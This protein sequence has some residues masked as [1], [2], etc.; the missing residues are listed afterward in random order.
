GGAGFIGSNTVRTLVARG[1]RV[2]VLD[3]LFLGR[4][5]NLD[6][7]DCI[8]VDGDALDGKLLQRIAKKHAIKQVY[9]FSGYT[10]APMYNDGPAT[11]MVKNLQG[12]LNILELSR[13]HALRVAYA[14]TSSFYARSPK[15]FREDMSI[16]PGTPYEF[17]KLT[18]ENAAHTYFLENGVRS[19]GLRFFSVYGPREA[20]KTR[21]ANNISQFFWSI[22]N[23]ISPVVFGDG[24]QTRDF[25]FVDDLVDGILGVMEKGRESDVYNIGTGTEHSFN[26]MIQIINEELGTDVEPRYI[27]NPLRN[28]VQE[29]LADTSKIQN[30]VGWRPKTS[31]REGIRKLKEADEPYSKAQ[32][33][34][35]YSWLK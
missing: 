22:R 14:S 4:W 5:S 9:H 29:T 26:D 31:L 12:F 34:A 35:L 20:H 19:N 17:S 3:N 24:S 27:K 7:V 6:G 13:E 18:M 33:R 32:A 15:P 28:Y 30:E 25:T 1:E 23:Q 10:S 2:I 16:T 8:R 11:K 21:Y